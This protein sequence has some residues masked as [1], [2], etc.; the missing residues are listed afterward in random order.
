MSNLDLLDDLVEIG[1][2]LRA[3]GKELQPLFDRVAD[4]GD[5]KGED[6]F[7]SLPE[8]DQE[9]LALHARM[10]A[11]TLHTPEV[12]AVPSMDRAM[13]RHERVYADGRIAAYQE[14]ERV[15]PGNAGS[16]VQFDRNLPDADVGALPYYPP[17]PASRPSP[18]DT[19]TDD[20]T[21]EQLIKRYLASLSE[22]KKAARRS[23][24]TALRH[25]RRIL[26]EV[27]GQETLK[28]SEI[29]P[30]HVR[31][32][33]AVLPKWPRHDRY[34]SADTIEELVAL[35]CEK[36]S[37]KTVSNR[38]MIVRMFFNWAFEQGYT[39]ADHLVKICRVSK[40]QSRGG[41]SIF[42]SEDLR[43]LF[44]S[45]EYMS[46]SFK[47]H[48]EYWI[49]LIGTHTGA[50]QAEICQLHTADVSR[51]RD[52]QWWFDINKNADKRL[53]TKE[54]QRLVPVHSRLLDLGLADYVQFRKDDTNPRLFPEEIRNDR[55]EFHAYS[56]R[57]NRYRKDKGV[58]GENGMRK[59]FHSFRHTVADALMRGGKVPEH[60]ANWFVGHRPSNVSETRRT[61]SHGPDPSA[62]IECLQHLNFEIDFSKIKKWSLQLGTQGSPG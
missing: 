57:F 45:E 58:E 50:R 15:I 7:F 29:K 44:E 47:R 54:S 22:D 23:Y 59:D 51:D 49:P 17:A 6:F 4:G 27:A 5:D 35:E 10:E 30:A 28:S 41:R 43:K 2:R 53:K 62:L 56:G 52:G 36:L 48:S 13:E 20:I 3:R 60:I 19:A 24:E 32:Y 33:V 18:Q 40:A 25:L 39:I 21:L 1:A 31:H 38:L 37:A 46:G 12:A 14:M 26:V 16:R 9:A 11:T 34:K 61:Y 42:T 55:D 8:Y